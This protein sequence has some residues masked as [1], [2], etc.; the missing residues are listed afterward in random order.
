MNASGSPLLLV[1][2]LLRLENAEKDDKTA[3]RGGELEDAD[4]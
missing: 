3:N 1:V 2:G 4:T